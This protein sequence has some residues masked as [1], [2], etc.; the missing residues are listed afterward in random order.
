MFAVTGSAGRVG[1]VVAR[2]LLS[3]DQLVRAVVRDRDGRYRRIH[4][5][6]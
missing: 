2:G 3:A 4:N 5:S 1:A 6:T